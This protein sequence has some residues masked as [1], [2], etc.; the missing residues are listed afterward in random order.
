MP[1]PRAGLTI[2]V[3]VGKRHPPRSLPSRARSSPCPRIASTYLYYDAAIYGD[4]HGHILKP[5]TIP[6]FEFTYRIR[7]S[8]YRAAALFMATQHH[9]DL[10]IRAR[11]PWSRFSACS[12]FS[13]IVSKLGILSRSLADVGSLRVSRELTLL[14]FHPC[15]HRLDARPDPSSTYYYVHQRLVE[16]LAR[17]LQQKGKQREQDATDATAATVLGIPHPRVCSAHL[18]SAI[19]Y[20]SA[21]LA[22]SIGFSL[23]PPPT[24][25]IQSTPPRLAPAIHTPPPRPRISQQTAHF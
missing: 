9:V 4:L 16:Q 18:S 17:P 20:P 14:L 24:Y 21:A 13:L 3:H 5:I 8:S 1:I 15:V 11:H 23:I 22:N 19:C 2:S 12:T 10:D 7:Y 6:G 25:I